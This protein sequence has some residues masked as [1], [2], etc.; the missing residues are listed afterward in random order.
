MCHHPLLDSM[1]GHFWPAVSISLLA[2][3]ASATLPAPTPPPHLWALI[4]L[5]LSA[6]SPSGTLLHSLY[7]NSPYSISTASSAF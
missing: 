3:A 6:A 5:C 2:L 7:S 4:C 1:C